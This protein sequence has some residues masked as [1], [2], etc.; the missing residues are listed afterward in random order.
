MLIPFGQGPVTAVRIINPYR[1]E[2]EDGKILNKMLLEAT[3]GK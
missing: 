2:K 1:S 3:G